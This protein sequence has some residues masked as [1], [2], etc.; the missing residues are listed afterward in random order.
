MYNVELR[1]KELGYHFVKE[2]KITF[3]LRSGQVKLFAKSIGNNS[4]S[5]V[6]V[7]GNDIVSYNGVSKKE[8]EKIR[9][10]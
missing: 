4:Y 8:L 10:Y 9:G 2:E 6:Y 3:G 7:S 1:L 5:K